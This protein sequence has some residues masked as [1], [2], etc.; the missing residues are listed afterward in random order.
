MKNLLIVSLL[1]FSI[2]LLLIILK[3][4]FIYSS[5]FYYRIII[6]PKDGFSITPIYVNHDKLFID[7]NKV[8]RAIKINEFFKKYPHIKKAL[9]KAKIIH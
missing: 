6:A 2:I 9:I 5:D 8:N 1:L 3:T 7:E 4:T